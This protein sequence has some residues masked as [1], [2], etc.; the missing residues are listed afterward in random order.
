M[1]GDTPPFVK[2][3]VWDLDNTLWRGTLLEDERVRLDDAVREVVVRLD[4]RG[5][6]QSVASKNDHDLAWRRLEELGVADYF[7]V[8]MIGWGPKSESIRRIAEEL[9]FAHDTL[10]FVDDQPA[11]RAEVAFRLPEVRCYSHDQV[12]TLADLPE[13]TPTRTTGDARN[14]RAMYRAGF[15]RRSAQDEFEGADIDFLRTLGMQLNIGHATDEDISRVEELTLRT[16]QMNATGVHYPDHVLRGLVDDPRHAV[17]VATL[18]DRFGTHGAIGVVLVRLEA[19]VWHLKLLATSCRVVS[20]GIGGAILNWLIGQAH[21]AGA[22]LV[23][24]FRRTDRNRMMDITYRLAGF[25]EDGCPCARQPAAGAEPDGVVGLHL[26][27][28]ARTVPDTIALT[29]PTLAGTG[30]AGN[31]SATA[32]E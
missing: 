18:T 20:F 7:V 19:E 30:P 22:H 3:L 12:R 17:L 8:P 31:R 15:R 9:S 1:F 21:E 24:D 5:S 32:C 29:A 28:D 11:E 27:P 26:V 4:A 23:A 6:L 25:A 10:A 13:F 2:C 16:S 14:R